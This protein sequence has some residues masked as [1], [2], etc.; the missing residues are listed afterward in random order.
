MSCWRCS[1]ERDKL[2]MFGGQVQLE[3]N[4][5]TST[6]YTSL[7]KC[8]AREAN[9]AVGQYDWDYSA[10]GMNFLSNGGF[11]FESQLFF[12]NT[13]EKMMCNKKCN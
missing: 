1:L 5:T 3:F 9:R 2:A 4:P 12:S 13:F 7:L 11:A 10:N 8:L 6:S